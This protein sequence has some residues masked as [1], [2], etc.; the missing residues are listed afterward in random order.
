MLPKV[1]SWRDAGDTPGRKNQEKEAKLQHLHTASPH[2]ASPRHME[3][4]GGLPGCQTPAPTLLGRS[5]GKQISGTWY[6]LGQI[7][8]APWTDRPLPREKRK[9]KLNNKQL[10]KKKTCSKESGAP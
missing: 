4:P 6:S 1:N 2:I 8:T 7:S 5:P 9:K 3:K 10:K